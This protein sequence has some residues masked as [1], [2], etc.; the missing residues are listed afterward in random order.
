MNSI[1]S[2]MLEAI[3]IFG[4]TVGSATGITDKLEKGF[5]WKLSR[6][7]EKSDVNASE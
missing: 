2:R 1:V 5:L 3:M 7:G 4:S 6:G